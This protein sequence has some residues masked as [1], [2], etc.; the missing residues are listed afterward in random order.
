MK[1]DQARELKAVIIEK[2]KDKYGIQGV[3]LINLGGDEYAVQ[4]NV[5]PERL[6]LISYKYRYEILEGKVVVEK[7]PHIEAQ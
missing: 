6:A 1:L 7:T 4:I 2:L 5:I 3:G